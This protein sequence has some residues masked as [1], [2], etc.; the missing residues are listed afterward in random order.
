MPETGRGLGGVAAGNLAGGSTAVTS[1]H[2]NRSSHAA[3][4]ANPGLES[5]R[6][7]YSSQRSSDRPIIT[8]MPVF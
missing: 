5:E 4:L 1:A 2:Q 3:A 6:Q 8:P 7:R